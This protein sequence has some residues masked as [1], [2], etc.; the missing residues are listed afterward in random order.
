MKTKELN[1]YSK[2]VV[3]VLLTVVCSLF[4]IQAQHVTIGSQIP[5][6]KGAVLDL[7]ESNDLTGNANSTSGLMMARVALSDV[8]NLFPMLTG[9]ES[10]YESLKP[11]YTGLIVYNVTANSSLKKG[12]YSWNGSNWSKLDAPVANSVTA[13][14]G[15]SVPDGQNVELGGNL[16][17]NTTINHNG[18]ILNFNPNSGK[19]GVNVQDPK[20]IMDITN[21]V[22]EDPLILRNVRNT[23]V[24]SDVTYYGLKA[25]NNGVIRKAQPVIVN[26]S[27]SFIYNL[28]TPTIDGNG[29]GRI[30]IGTSETTLNWRVGTGSS[31]SIITLPETGVFLFSFRFYGDVSGTTNSSGSFCINTYKNSTLY[32]RETLI[33]RY[34]LTLWPEAT[35]SMTIPVSGN[36]GDKV[37]FTFVKT[38][39]STN[40]TLK[41]GSDNMANRTSL[42]FW[43]Q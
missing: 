21:N 27:Q 26:P 3:L 1:I 28:Y 36:A 5:P 22:N 24:E 13:E 30:T 7:K 33:V 17:E 18:Y 32:Y 34:L 16:E 9:A 20:A 4:S 43:K 29:N 40:W 19:I 31:S 15:L 41:T 37:Y 10:D 25:S 14:N 42:V 12:L 2:K 6:L 35:Y 11:K 8:N 39:G 38:G 23:S